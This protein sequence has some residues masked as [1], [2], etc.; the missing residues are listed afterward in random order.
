[1]KAALRASLHKANSQLGASTSAVLDHSSGASGEDEDLT[2]A[3]MMSLESNSFHDEVLGKL[4]YTVNNFFPQIFSSCI[5]LRT[6]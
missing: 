2:K 3:V 1:M 4:F 5:C 6:R